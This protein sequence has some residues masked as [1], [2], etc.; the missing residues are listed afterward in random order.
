MNQLN[1]TKPSE[2]ML[3]SYISTPFGE[4]YFRSLFKLYKKVTKNRSRRAQIENPVP[5][6]P[7]SGP[8]REPKSDQ[9]VTN[10]HPWD[11]GV[12]QIAPRGPPGGPKG[13]ILDESEPFWA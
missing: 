8:K 6:W 3:K 7:K 5:K 1:L 12:T 10:G 4:V 11:P 13:T 2:S 9:K